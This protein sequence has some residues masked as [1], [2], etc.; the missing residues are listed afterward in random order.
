MDELAALPPE[1]PPRLCPHCG[2]DVSR[3]PASRVSHCPACGGALSLQGVNS[4]LFPKRSTLWLL[5]WL[6]L[7]GG[8]LLT[9]ASPL[10][11]RW[12]GSFPGLIFPKMMRA[13][14]GG[15]LA[16]LT[17]GVSALGAGFALA[18]LITKTQTSFVIAGILL[19]LGVLVLY[20]AIVFIGCVAAMKGFH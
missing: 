5:F 12:L 17:A 6:F 8:P 13:V 3:E 9:L 18:R 2:S 10:V 19:S 14:G 15:R 4:I 1:H 16:L 7:V 20:G 11:G